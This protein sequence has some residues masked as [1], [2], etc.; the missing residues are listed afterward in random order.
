MTFLFAI[1]KP[2][3]HVVGDKPQ[4]YGFVGD[5]PQ[6]YVFRDRDVP[7]TIKEISAHLPV[8]PAP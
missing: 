5:E 8:L 2:L 4:R 7:P 1:G 3:P 6:R